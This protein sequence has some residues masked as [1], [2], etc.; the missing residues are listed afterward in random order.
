MKEETELY[1]KLVS[2]AV[3]GLAANPNFSNS[4]PKEFAELALQIADHAIDGVLA[5]EESEKEKEAEMGAPQMDKVFSGP[6][7]MRL[8]KT[9]QRDPI[10]SQTRSYLNMLILPSLAN[11][12]K[13]PVKSYVMRKPGARTGV[14]LVDV[15]SLTRFIEKHAQKPAP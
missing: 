13:P 7:F 9:G 11:E 15:E 1:L 5:I 8:P 4:T 12:F 3:Q 2:A 14:R 10:F 6:K